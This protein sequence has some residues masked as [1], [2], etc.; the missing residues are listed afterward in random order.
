[1]P[2][3]PATKEVPC[4]FCNEPVEIELIDP[5]YGDYE[6]VPP[7]GHVCGEDPKMV[8]ISGEKES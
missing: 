1:M 3:H 8:E 4:P 2:N 5:E 7:K 6:P